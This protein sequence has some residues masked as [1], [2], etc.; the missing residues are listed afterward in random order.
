MSRYDDIGASPTR[1]GI[2]LLNGIGQ[3]HA[4]DPAVG[5]VKKKVAK[6]K[7]P[8]LFREGQFSIPVCFM[9]V[10]LPLPFYQ[11]RTNNTWHYQMKN[12]WVHEFI[13]RL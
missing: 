13:A 9:S 2:R 12:H 7:R 10:I 4:T 1:S 11:L 6:N 8:S 5:Y 3:A